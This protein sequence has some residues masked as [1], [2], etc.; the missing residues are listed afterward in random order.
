M[1]GEQTARGFPL[2]VANGLEE[3]AGAAQGVEGPE[4]ALQESLQFRQP[5]RLGRKARR[6]QD[7]VH[8]VFFHRRVQGP[9]HAQDQFDLPAPE[10]R[11]ADGPVGLAV[12]GQG[13]RG[14]RSPARGQ[15][16]GHAQVEGMA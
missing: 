13:D 10:P 14:V 9:A 3:V 7:L 12:V 16:L 8:A 2:A 5:R 11:T 6:P 15:L 4:A 1:P